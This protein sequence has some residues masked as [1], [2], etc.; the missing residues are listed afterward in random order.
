METYP[1]LLGEVG[2]IA[3]LL[4]KEIV[5]NNSNEEI[6]NHIGVLLRL[7]IFNILP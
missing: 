7:R 5:S 6:L 2:D 1:R 4:V 3:S